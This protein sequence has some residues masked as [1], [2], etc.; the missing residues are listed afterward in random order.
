MKI[1]EAQL[2]EKLLE[3]LIQLSGEW[4]TENCT[5]GYRKNNREDIQWNRI[6]LAEIN[7]SIAGYLF[8]R[9]DRAE[10]S[11]SIMADGTEFFEVEEL[12]IVPGLRG[13][14]IGSA[15]FRYAEQQVKAEGV[16]FIMLSTAT[17]EYKQIL[18]FYI[19]E[20][21]MEFWS[22]RLFKQL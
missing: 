2:S 6:F 15:L 19:E 8:G 5:Y 13:Q 21:E 11:R 14:G 4:E 10:H 20:L 7:G 22:A 1:Y 17:K 18:R 9:R 3:K 12:Y 16:Q